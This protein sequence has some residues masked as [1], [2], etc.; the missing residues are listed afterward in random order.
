MRM[1]E[2]KRRRSLQA[3]RLARE[4]KVE[5]SLAIWQKEIVPDW[6]IVREKPRLRSLWWSG[7]PSK[8]RANMWERVVGNALALSKGTDLV[9]SFHH[10]TYSQ[11][12]IDSY[13]IC[14]SRAKRALAAGTFPTTTLQLIED[15][16][17]TTL[18]SL[19]IFNAQTGPMYEDLKDILLA[20]VVSRSDE[21]LGYTRGIAKLA[22]M[23]I[24]NMPSPQGFVV[25]RNLLERHC[26][27]SFYGGISTK[28][29]VSRFLPLHCS[30]LIV[31]AARLKPTIGE[32]PAWESLVALTYDAEYSTHCLRMEC[33]RVG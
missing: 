8:L 11:L 2:E 16:V 4:V 9:A 28:D 24:L 33:R 22:A 25:L 32:K 23:I 3:R 20:W 18:P 7:I 30:T 1:L 12:D 19:H 17:S 6:K 5:E 31:E 14:L 10:T 15:D 21:G 27:R 26:M 29:D 13:R